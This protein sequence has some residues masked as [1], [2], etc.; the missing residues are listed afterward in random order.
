MV[1]LSK[2]KVPLQRSGEENFR[3]AKI[4]LQVWT[5][6]SLD[7]FNNP[8]DVQGRYFLTQKDSHYEAC[9]DTPGRDPRR[10]IHSDALRLRVFELNSSCISP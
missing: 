4:Y 9:K 3:I 6:R 1:P 5:Q 2:I 10:R 8:L 7:K